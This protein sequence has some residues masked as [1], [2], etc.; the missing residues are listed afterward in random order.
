MRAVLDTCVLY[1]PILREI[2]IGVASAGV[3]EPIWSDRILDEWRGVARRDGPANEALVGGEI[4]LLR[5]HF[6]NAEYK[7]HEAD[8]A[9][10]Y[11]PDT[12]D[13]HVLALARTAQ[14]NAIVT[15]NLKDFPKQ[16]LAPYGVSAIHPDAFLCSLCTETPSAVG[17][18]VQQ[19]LAQA[20]DMSGQDIAARA[21][22][23]RA[24]LP[25]LAKLLAQAQ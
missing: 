1:P 2:L 5:A 16:D 9:D 18:I 21:L 25:R 11:L 3:F 14:C 6:P 10:L 8:N 24:R 19:V 17:D 12:G 4:A 23:K 20:R 22:L 13:V 15:A 7:I